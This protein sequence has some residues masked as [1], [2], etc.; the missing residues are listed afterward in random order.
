MCNNQNNP[1]NVICK[2]GS[3][4]SLVND[5]QNAAFSGAAPAFRHNTEKFTGGVD[6]PSIRADPR[7]NI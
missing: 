2:Q 1:P 5:L 3:N 7:S 4:Y 6:A